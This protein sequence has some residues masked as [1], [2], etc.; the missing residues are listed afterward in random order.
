MNL[1]LEQQR[2]LLWNKAQRVL[3]KSNSADD[4]WVPIPKSCLDELHHALLMTSE[5]GRMIPSIGRIV[6]YT[7]TQQDA[8]AINGRRNDGRSHKAECDDNGGWQE[9]IPV[10]N[11][12]GE[13]DVYPM[14]ITRVWSDEPTEST[15]VNGQVYLD[16]ND[17]HWVTSVSQLPEL[18][19]DQKYDVTATYRTWREPRRV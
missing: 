15:S 8:D 16:G 3:N 6:H 14:M 13:G 19:E 12:V 11:A 2:D 1:D 17:I 7:L 5:R 10:G 4:T 18:P 9:S